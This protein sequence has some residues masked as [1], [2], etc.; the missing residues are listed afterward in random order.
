VPVVTVVILW[1]SSHTIRAALARSAVL[2]GAAQESDAAVYIAQGSPD[3]EVVVQGRDLTPFTNAQEN[4]LQQK[5]FLLLK[6][7]KSKLTPTRVKIQ[8]AGAGKQVTGVVFFFPK[9]T[10]AGEPTA[11]PTKPLSNS[12]AR[13]DALRFKPASTYA[14]WPICT[15]AISNSVFSGN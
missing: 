1:A 11:S 10:P 4:G 8:H 6:G 2:H 3:Y 13:L 7:S 12:L 9:N 15:A 5:T 14:Q